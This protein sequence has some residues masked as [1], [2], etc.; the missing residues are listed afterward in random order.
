MESSARSRRAS[1]S[2]IAESRPSMPASPA[3]STRSST[4]PAAFWKTFWTISTFWMRA[5]SMTRCWRARS[6]DRIS[7]RPSCMR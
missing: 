3:V 2:E 4:R 5:G 7:S 1:A 6:P